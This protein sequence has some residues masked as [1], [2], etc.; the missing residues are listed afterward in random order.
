[1]Y[2]VHYSFFLSTHCPSH[3]PLFWQSDPIGWNC[4]W[5]QMLQI[6]SAEWKKIRAQ[7]L[8]FLPIVN[9]KGG[10][11]ASK[12]YS[13]FCFVSDREECQLQGTFFEMRKYCSLNYSY[14]IWNLKNTYNYIAQANFNRNYLQINFKLKLLLQFLR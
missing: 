11:V 4:G 6:P 3:C 7:I 5:K 8:H 13:F 2:P 1:M 9:S 12:V 14:H 10:R